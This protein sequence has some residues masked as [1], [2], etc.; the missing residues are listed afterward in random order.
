MFLP[1]AAGSKE[2]GDQ[3]FPFPLSKDAFARFRR[4][5]DEQTFFD[6]NERFVDPADGRAHLVVFDG[7]GRSL[8]IRAGGRTKS[9]H[10]LE[11]DLQEKLPAE[12]RAQIKRFM[13]V[14]ASLEELTTRSDIVRFAA[15][16]SRY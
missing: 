11:G 8:T 2:S 4:C 16:D 9:V 6:L 13:N 5:L 3:R 1:R 15:M 14:W 7:W 10:L 12:T